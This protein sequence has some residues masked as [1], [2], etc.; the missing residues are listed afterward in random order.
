MHMLDKSDNRTDRST[1]F[2]GSAADVQ[3]FDGAEVLAPNDLYMLP[4]LP[5][6][7][8]G[9]VFLVCAQFCMHFTCI[10]I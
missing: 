10:L 1:D 5:S 9:H 3:V 7:G 4:Q 8:R 2:G 6:T